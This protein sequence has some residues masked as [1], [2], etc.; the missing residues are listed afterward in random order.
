MSNGSRR[1]QEASIDFAATDPRMKGTRDDVFCAAY[2]IG[3]Q[4]AARVILESRDQRIRKL[5]EAA[6]IVLEATAALH[7]AVSES[8]A[9]LTAI[10]RL[11]HARD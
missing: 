3:F 8:G 4:T 7:P 9:W 1:A 10:S 2:D 5:E 11:R 6:D